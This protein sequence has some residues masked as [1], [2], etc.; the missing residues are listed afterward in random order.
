VD[1][2]IAGP[3]GRGPRTVG[4]GGRLCATDREAQSGQDQHGERDAH[5]RDA[6]GT[7]MG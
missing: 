5:E 3:A 4:A 1:T 2:R 6:Q 7:L